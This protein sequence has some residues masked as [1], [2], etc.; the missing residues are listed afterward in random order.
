MPRISQKQIKANRNR[1]LEHPCCV[2]NESH[3][4]DPIRQSIDAN[5]HS[6]E[7]G[8]HEGREFGKES[9]LLV[10]KAR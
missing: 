6:G 1:W 5:G 2:G 7:H 3:N 8:I 4:D 10:C 9:R